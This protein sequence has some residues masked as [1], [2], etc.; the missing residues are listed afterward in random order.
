ML[1]TIQLLTY[2]L[3]QTIISYYHSIK[4]HVWILSYLQTLQYHNQNHNLLK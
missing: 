1:N 2:E 3:L 4:C